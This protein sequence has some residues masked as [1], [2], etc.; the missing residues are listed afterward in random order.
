[1][2][3]GKLA[4]GTNDTIL[5]DASTQCVALLLVTHNYPQYTY[6]FIVCVSELSNEIYTGMWNEQN[7]I[8]ASM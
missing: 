3:Y 1:M 4:L 8:L 2:D 5:N 7:I 6:C